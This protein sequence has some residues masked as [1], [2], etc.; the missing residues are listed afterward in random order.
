[1]EIAANTDSPPRA[2]SA[3][4]HLRTAGSTALIAVALLAG[5]ATPQPVDTSPKPLDL[6]VRYP[7][8][9]QRVQATG[10]VHLRVRFDAAGTV[11]DVQIVQSTGNRELDAEA[12]RATQAMRVQPGTRNGVPQAG[13]LQ[14]PIRFVLE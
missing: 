11:K 6:Q 3:L 1:M 12:L 5:C 8:A 14:L 2:A 13:V 9:A 10:S 7:T 4:T